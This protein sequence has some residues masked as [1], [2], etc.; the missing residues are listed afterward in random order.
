MQRHPWAL[1]AIVISIFEGVLEVFDTK[2]TGL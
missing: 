2:N 1:H